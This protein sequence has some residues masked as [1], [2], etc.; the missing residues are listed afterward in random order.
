MGRARWQA[1]AAFVAR[2][3][4]SVQN[5]TYRPVRCR[6][7][8]TRP[9]LPCLAGLATRETASIT[10]CT[11]A[12][13]LTARSGRTRVCISSPCSG[14]AAMLVFNKDISSFSTPGLRSPASVSAGWYW[15][16]AA[17][18]TSNGAAM[19]RNPELWRALLT[20]FLADANAPPSPE[21]MDSPWAGSAS[22]ERCELWC[23]TGGQNVFATPVVVLA[24]NIALPSTNAR[25]LDMTL[26]RTPKGGPSLITVYKDNPGSTNGTSRSHCGRSKGR[27]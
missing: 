6:C 2:V 8:R 17:K 4:Y 12:S 13:S 23:P 25:L 9:I 18:L 26:I 3:L 16:C 24:P 15:R 21:S 10:Y 14:L 27:T 20:A 22:D 5:G 7:S 1:S 11:Y 19:S